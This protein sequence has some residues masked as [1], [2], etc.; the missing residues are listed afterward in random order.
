MIIIRRSLLALVLTVVGTS[1][2]SGAV[3]WEG[4]RRAL[5]FGSSDT[6]LAIARQ[7]SR[8]CRRVDVID[9]PTRAVRRI[10]SPT[11]R[12][13][14]ECNG[15]PGSVRTIESIVV[16]GRRAWWISRAFSHSGD[17]RWVS[18]AGIGVPE[19]RRGELFEATG[20]VDSGD[21][22]T[23][24]IDG[25]V[26]A[27]GR[28]VVAIRR[29]VLSPNCVPAAGGDATLAHQ[30]IRPTGAVLA[31]ASSGVIAADGERIVLGGGD[32][33]LFLFTPGGAPL[34]QV[35][36][37][38]PA[39]SVAVAGDVIWAILTH[40]G[41]ARRKL[42]RITGAP[43]APV[44]HEFVVPAEADGL[45]A[46]GD[47]VAFHTTSE[48]YRARTAVVLVART[49]PRVPNGRTVLGVRIAAGRL[50]WATDGGR[51]QTTRIHV[52]PLP[53]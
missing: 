4:P 36:L 32:G 39:V 33:S 30:L 50:F 11:R 40:H 31:D 26:L 37:P 3:F 17:V 5:A 38:D 24:E 14:Y 34:G 8:G 42:V 21:P 51:P 9:I 7:V 20:N 25:L 6:T 12:I 1:T 52:V 49:K 44:L 41:V 23:S 10:T 35:A 15:S 2:A 48:V 16:A 22:G 27:G 47:D 13:G 28:P 18:R 53:E 29:C 43:A 45:A 46:M 19:T